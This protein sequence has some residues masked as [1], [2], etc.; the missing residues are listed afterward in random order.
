MTHRS[1]AVTRLAAALGLAGTVYAGALGAQAR[2]GGDDGRARGAPARTAEERAQLERRFEERLAAVVQRELRT[3]PEQT[4][5]L[6]TVSRRFEQQRRPLFQREMALRRELRQQLG[7]SS[8][9][10][11]RVET[12]MREM[13]QLQRRRIDL[14][15]AEQRELAEFLTPVQ[16]AR[17]LALQE[18][19]RHR[20]EQRGRAGRSRAAA[21]GSPPSSRRP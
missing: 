8:P 18:N 10:D 15:E 2:P 11:R 4:Q 7:A 20:V 12:A 16:R 9:D 14:I 1:F 21:P 13:L 5:R 3:T 17:Y 6:G 19:L